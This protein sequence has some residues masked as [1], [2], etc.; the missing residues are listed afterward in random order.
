MTVT[1]TMRYYALVATVAILAA[2][3]ASA[4]AHPRPLL[5]YDSIWEQIM[6]ARKHEVPEEFTCKP[7][8]QEPISQEGVCL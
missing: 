1:I 7:Q 2:G 3:C 5:R 6:E 4:P 8:S